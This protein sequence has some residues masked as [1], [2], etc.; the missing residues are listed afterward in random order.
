MPSPRVFA[1]PQ[2]SFAVSGSFGGIRRSGCGRKI[3]NVFML[4]GGKRGFVSFPLAWPGKS[5]LLSRRHKPVPHGTTWRRAEY[6]GLPGLQ[7]PR[8]PHGRQRISRSRTVLATKLC[9]GCR[10]AECIRPLRPARAAG[11]L[12][13][14]VSEKLDAEK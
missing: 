13:I 14:T 11:Q 8:P 10:V 2:L 12:P 4:R 7:R 3:Y 6:L 9:A 5:A 1:R